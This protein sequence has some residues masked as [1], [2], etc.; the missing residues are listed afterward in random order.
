MKRSHRFLALGLLVG[1]LM[2]ILGVGGRSHAEEHLFNSRCAECHDNDSVTC[3]GCHRHRGVIHA[4]AD[5]DTYN[6]G[7]SITVTLSSTGAEP[8]W[9]RGILYDHEG[10]AIDCAHG[11]NWEGDDGLGSPVEFPVDLH[12]TAPLEEGNYTWE[13]AWFGGNNYGTDHLEQRT[14]ATFTVEI[15]TDVPEGWNATEGRLSLTVYPNPLTHSAALRFRGSSPG[16]Q[17]SL[18]V[19]DP[20]GR[21]V[22]DLGSRAASSEVEEV[23][24]D[25]T[26]MAGRRVPAGTY[27]VVLATA[28]G[29]LARSV[30]VLR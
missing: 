30:L 21:L 12:G 15:S 16:E 11:P 25:G 7:Q 28:H 2:L 29:S 4:T 14:P 6:P 17:V 18:S 1:V 22:R 13:A 23:S 10:V 26:D 9:I 5:R 3:A 24:W 8:G 19:F 20:T 27:L